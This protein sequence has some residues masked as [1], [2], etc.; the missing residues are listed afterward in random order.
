MAEI[1]QQRSAFARRRPPRHILGNPYR[2]ALDLRS[3]AWSAGRA[4]RADWRV[5]RS[6]AG[7]YLRV[8]PFPSVSAAARVSPLNR[9]ALSAELSAGLTT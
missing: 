6:G 2:E 1:S 8:A 5:A 7:G 9:P 4:M 3:Q